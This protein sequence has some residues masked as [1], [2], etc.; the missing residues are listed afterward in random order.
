MIVCIGGEQ[1]GTVGVPLNPLIIHMPDSEAFTKVQFVL[2]KGKGRFT[3]RD[4][5]IDQSGE[6]VAE[7]IPESPGRYRIECRSYGQAI[8]CFKGVVTGERRQLP[9]PPTFDLSDTPEPVSDRPAGL[10]AIATMISEEV[11]TVAVPPGI[12]IPIP[13]PPVLPADPSNISALQPILEPEA[14]P[15]PKQ[16]VAEK[17]VATKAVP[18]RRRKPLKRHPLREAFR[19]LLAMAITVALTYGLGIGAGAIWDKF[20]G[21][22][23][24]PAQTVGKTVTKSPPDCTSGRV[25]VRDGKLMITGCGSR[26]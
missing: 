17:E 10:E 1:R 2:V 5:K 15:E 20:Q 12:Q 11:D 22:T 24:E 4:S 7:F 18:V 16:E 14:D 6:A 21:P 23:T 25:F 19:I 8:G 9:E 26:P 13:V 3:H